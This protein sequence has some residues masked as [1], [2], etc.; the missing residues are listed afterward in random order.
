MLGHDEKARLFQMLCIV[1]VATPNGVIECCADAG[2]CIMNPGGTGD[3]F[4]SNMKVWFVLDVVR[5]SC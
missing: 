2:I 4:S 3:E 1:V 5:Q